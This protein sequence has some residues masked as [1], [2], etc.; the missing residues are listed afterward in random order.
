MDGHPGMQPFSQSDRGGPSNAGPQRRRGLAPDPSGPSDESED[1]PEDW[2]LEPGQLANFADGLQSQLKHLASC[3]ERNAFQMFSE[4]KGEFRVLATDLSRELYRLAQTNNQLNA[5]SERNTAT[6]IANLGTGFGHLLFRLDHNIKQNFE[7]LSAENT[8]AIRRIYDV[9][10][11]QARVMDRIE[12]ETVDMKHSLYVM[13]W[14]R[15]CLEWLA[16]KIWQGLSFCVAC[17]VALWTILAPWVTFDWL[18]FLVQWLFPPAVPY[19]RSAQERVRR[20]LSRLYHPWTAWAAV[21][22]LAVGCRIALRNWAMQD[23][24]WSWARDYSTEYGRT[25]ASDCDRVYRGYVDRFAY[26]IPPEYQ[27]QGWRWSMEANRFVKSG[28]HWDEKAKDFVRDRFSKYLKPTELAKAPKGGKSG[29]T[30]LPEEPKQTGTEQK[31]PGGKMAEESMLQV[32]LQALIDTSREAAE[33]A[34]KA[35]II[36]MKVSKTLALT[37]DIVL[38]AKPECG[39]VDTEFE[40]DA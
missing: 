23:P 20:W 10:L 24:L 25:Y 38:N 12:R 7:E 8:A 27:A 19:V 13:A 1:S 5:S 35:V 30:V 31:E 14:E 28:S 3:S 39:K 40:V 37:S 21:L 26:G 2:G 22:L 33:E 32:D 16:R 9:Q 4:I 29:K 15:L 36:S 17:V 6:S 11:D 18:G 34:A